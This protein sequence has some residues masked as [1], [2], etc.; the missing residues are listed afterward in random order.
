MCV[1]VCVCVFVRYGNTHTHIVSASSLLKK[2]I[3]SNWQKLLVGPHVIP[4]AIQASTATCVKSIITH[5]FSCGA[6]ELLLTHIPCPRKS[7]E[8][9]V[10]CCRRTSIN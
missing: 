2:A 8:L 4:Q 7:F 9:H 10:D 5:V 6:S 3:T 1:C